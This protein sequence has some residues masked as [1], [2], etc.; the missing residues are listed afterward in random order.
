[1]AMKGA[2]RYLG[3]PPKIWAVKGR[4][5]KILSLRKETMRT[6]KLIRAI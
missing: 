3:G 1:M 4:P 2:G 5:L 6:T